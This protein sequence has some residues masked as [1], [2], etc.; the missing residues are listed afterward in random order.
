M[1]REKKNVRPKTFKLQ[2][3]NKLWQAGRI[4]AFELV[5]TVY[6]VWKKDMRI[7]VICLVKKDYMMFQNG[8][9]LNRESLLKDIVRYK[10]NGFQV[11]STE[12][13]SKE[14]EDEKIG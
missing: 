9:Y 13:T 2:V 8:V 5:K 10:A 14:I 12:N 11:F 6:D 4:T 7:G 1:K 3:G